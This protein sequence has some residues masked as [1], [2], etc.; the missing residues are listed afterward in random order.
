LNRY[1]LTPNRAP[2]N[3]FCRGLLGVSEGV[4]LLGTVRR[5]RGRK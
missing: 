5:L 1:G 3:L 4:E 2:R